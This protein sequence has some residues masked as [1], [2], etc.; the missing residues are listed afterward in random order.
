MTKVAHKLK[1]DTKKSYKLENILQAYC[2]LNQTQE[3]LYLET[4]VAKVVHVQDV[5][6]WSKKDYGRKKVDRK[7]GMLPPKVAR[8][9]VNLS[10]TPKDGVIYD[11]FCGSG[12]ILVEALDSG[13][14]AIGS[15]ISEKAVNDSVTNTNWFK[16]NKERSQR[17]D[18]VSQKYS[19]VTRSRS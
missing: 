5:N 10:Q 12:T 19:R 3:Y 16:K 11:P 13:F 6:W 17:C 2:N 9:M 8:I 18:G 15:D 1:V 14:A 4:L 7:S